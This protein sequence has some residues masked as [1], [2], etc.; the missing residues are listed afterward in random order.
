MVFMVADFSGDQGR[1]T[2]DYKEETIASFAS[3]YYRKPLL[4][5]LLLLSLTRNPVTRPADT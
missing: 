1:S 4:S 3:Y 5:F 2:R